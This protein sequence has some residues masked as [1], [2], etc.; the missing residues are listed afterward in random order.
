VCTEKEGVVLQTVLGPVRADQAGVIYAHEHLL[1]RPPAP[2]DEDADLILDD[3]SAAAAELRMF[4][5]AGGRT[6]VEASLPGFGRDIIA[7]AELSRATGVNLIACAGRHKAAYSERFDPEPTVAGLTEEFVA[8][9]TDGVSGLRPGI[10]KVA[11]SADCVRPIERTALL[12]AARASSATGVAITTHLQDG[13][14]GLEQVAILKEGGADPARLI[15]GHADRLM[16]AEY[17]ESILR[18][19]VFLQFDQIGHLKYGTDEA[20]AQGIVDLCRRGYGAQLCVSSDLGRRSYLR[21]YGGSPG[22][23]H[24]IRSF[25]PLLVGCGLSHEEAVALVT[26]NPCRALSVG[27]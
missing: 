13:R 21:A 1:G 14:L 6:L 25:I 22:L 16:D 24:V 23:E 15:I 5:E 27:A 12:A 26:T 9:L 19:G 11:S 17:H 8:E 18:Q 2:F 4:F 3:V 10:I 20:R 7:L